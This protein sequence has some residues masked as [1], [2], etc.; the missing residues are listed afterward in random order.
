MLRNASTCAVLCAWLAASAAAGAAASSPAPSASPRQATTACANPDLPAAILDGPPAEAP[1][2][3][4]PLITVAAPKAQL[5]L[6]VAADE[7]R[8]ELG[9]MCVTALRRHAGMIFVF[10]HDGPYEFWMKR[11]LIPLDMVWVAADGR[12]THV[13]AHAPSSTMDEPDDKVARRS[14]SGRYVI[15]LTAGEAALDGLTDGVRLALP[16][17]SASA[18]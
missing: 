14:G 12:V 9:L 5:H 1:K 11:T 3:P 7:A 6:A 16:A 4:L 18:S 10:A 13:A 8:R 2:T 15:E 17:L